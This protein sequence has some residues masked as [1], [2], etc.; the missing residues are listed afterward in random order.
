MLLAGICLSQ[1]GCSSVFSVNPLVAPADAKLDERLCGVWRPEPQEKPDSERGD[2][3]FLYLHI[4][5]AGDGFPAGVMKAITV[6]ERPDKTVRESQCLFLSTTVGDVTYVSIVSS[7]DGK[8]SDKWQP[9]QIKGYDLY[10][11]GVE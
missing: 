1:A 8:A 10:R 5:G 6:E 11:I 9:E 3:G 7:P 4:G 2:S